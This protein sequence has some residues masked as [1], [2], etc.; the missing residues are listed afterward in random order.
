MRLTEETRGVFVRDDERTDHFVAA[1]VRIILVEGLIVDLVQPEV[2]PAQV[3]EIRRIVGI[4]AQIAH[5]AEQDI[6]RVP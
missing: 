5:V 4:T 1:R 6:H 3:I 2:V